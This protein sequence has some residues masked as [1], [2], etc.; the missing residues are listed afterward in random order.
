MSAKISIALLRISLG[1]LFLY[2]GLSKLFPAISS[3]CAAAPASCKAWTA[4][5]FLKHAS[6]FPNLYSWFALPQNIGWVDFLN[7]WGLTLVGVALILGL[8]MRFTSICGILLMA[9]YYFPALNFPYVGTTAYIIDEHVIFVLLLILFIASSA[10]QIFGLDKYLK[11]S[12]L[13]QNKLVG[14]IFG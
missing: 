13:G 3:A 7:Q 6:T 1:L 4:A 9:L 12:T 10:G 14:W 5:G 11:R 8:A 2:A